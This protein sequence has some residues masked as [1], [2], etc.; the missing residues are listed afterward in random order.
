MFSETLHCSVSNFITF[1][2][3][4]SVFFVLEK[5]PRTLVPF[6]FC[7]W[8]IGLFKALLNRHLCHSLKDLLTDLKSFMNNHD[9]NH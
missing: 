8:F 2:V 1:L 5:E 7:E 6:S 9:M 4:P 3:R